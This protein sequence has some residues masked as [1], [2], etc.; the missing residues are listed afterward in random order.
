MNKKKRILCFCLSVILVFSTFTA[1]CKKKKTDHGSSS[2]TDSSSSSGSSDISDNSDSSDSSDDNSSVTDTV[3]SGS[4]GKHTNNSGSTSGGNS[5]NSGSKDNSSSGGNS[6]E[7]DT[8]NVT[9]VNPKTGTEVTGKNRD[10]SVSTKTVAYKNFYS[11]GGNTSPGILTDEGRKATGM[12]DA[13]FEIERSRLLS[14]RQ[15]FSRFLFPVDFM[16]TDTEENPK[17]SDWQNNKD[18]LN[19]KKGIY[20]FDNDRMKATYE[21]LDILKACG[22]KVY[23]NFGFQQNDRIAPW[24]LAIDSIS[25]SAPADTTLFANACAALMK[26]LIKDKGYN[27][28]IGVTFYNELNGH[29][30]QTVGSKDTYYASVVKKAYNA[31]QKAGLKNVGI[32]GPEVANIREDNHSWFDS[33]KSKVSKYMTGYTA[34]NYYTTLVNKGAGVT[35]VCDYDMLYSLG[36]YLYGNYS[37]NGKKSISITEF[38]TGNYDYNDMKNV[39]N[40]EGG[41][42]TWKTSNASYFIGCANS[43]ISGGSRWNY[44]GQYW[45][46]PFGF[47][48]FGNNYQ[49]L[50]L[51]P[52]STAAIEN[53]V[54]DKY[55]EDSLLT[56]YVKFGSD[57]LKINWTGTDT[58][59]AAFRLP[60]GNYTVV[61]EVNE[62]DTER[63]I[64][65]KFD[66]A[67]N[68]TFYKMSF[69]HD[70]VNDANAL[71]PSCEKTFTK[72]GKKLSDTVDSKYAYYVYT[73]CKPV[74]QIKLN[75]VTASVKAGGS[76]Q[77]KATLID[78]TSSDKVKWSIA[79]AVDKSGKNV[80]RR[81][82]VKD[83]KFTAD[84]GA[85]AGDVI[86]VRAELK[87]DPTVC[88]V[89]I[90]TV[91][92]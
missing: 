65:I 13:Y 6:D 22:T 75:K 54:L 90:I 45:T 69:S 63:N 3:N 78:A 55:Y 41:E 68:K 59:V 52:L 26:H 58:R 72:V 15:Q 38:N 21:Y 23:I 89:T 56:N 73:T 25:Y 57:V 61:V 30:F 14:A 12:N 39:A 24:F 19:Y 4:G 48:S 16:I 36:G 62:G 82:S 91:T 43:G 8:V 42:W 70:V 2:R 67:I 35:Q 1:G 32:F 17:R 5:N 66:K 34:H 64:S 92:D 40:S 7:D 44:S 83:G 29:G 37:E 31:L 50:W 80:S 86:A 33:L 76:V 18:Y 46:L 79:A 28:I 87:S 60:D 10:I 49:L 88:G 51:S 53:G 84:S 85:K 77:L 20:D 71:V 9:P 47:G 27:N 74:K 11:F 81:G